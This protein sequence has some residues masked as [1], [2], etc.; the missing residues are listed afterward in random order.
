MEKHPSSTAPLLH[1]PASAE[2]ATLPPRQQQDLF[3]DAPP[4][5]TPGGVP[6]RKVVVSTNIAETSITINGVR[7]SFPGDMATVEA[8]GSLTLLGRGSQVINSAGE[9][10]FPEEVEEAV[11]RV[12]GVLGSVR[13][14]L[15]GACKKQDADHQRAGG[16]ENQVKAAGAH[17]DT[18]YDG[19][20]G[21]KFL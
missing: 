6:G 4:P 16:K 10:I 11:K 18:V 19:S 8:D 12:D 3:K 13:T 9:K 15:A 21:E 2:S 1:A 17:G 7:Y 14:S 20:G 5:Y